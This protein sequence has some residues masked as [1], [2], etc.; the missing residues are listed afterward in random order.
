MRPDPVPAYEPPRIEL[1]LTAEALDRE[2]LYAGPASV[3]F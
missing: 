2:I 3:P 1:R